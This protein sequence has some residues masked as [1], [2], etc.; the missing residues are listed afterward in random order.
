MAE[1]KAEQE[2]LIAEARAEQ[3][4]RQYQLMAEIDTSK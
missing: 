4:V 3:M 2:K 1:A